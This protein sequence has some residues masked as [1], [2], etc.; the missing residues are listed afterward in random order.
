MKIRIYAQDAEPFSPGGGSPLTPT[1]CEI[2]ANLNSDWTL[3]LEHPLD[4]DGMYKLIQSG[5]VLRVPAFNGSQLYRII[6]A[7]RTDGGIT[8]T[9]EPIFMDAL[10]D[11]FFLDKRPTNLSGQA[12]LDYLMSGTKFSGESD[13]LNL[14]KAYYVRKNLIEALNG[15]DENAFTQRW[16]GEILFDN[17]KVII[18]QSAGRD[19]GVVVKYGR[20]LT[21]ITETVDRSSLITRIIPVGYNGIML[22]GS[23]PW[24]DSPLIDSYPIIYNSVIEYSDVKVKEDPD[25]PDEEGFDTLAEAQTEL[26]RLANLEY[27]QNNVDK[28]LVSMDVD[29]ILLQNTLEYAEFKDLEDISLGDTVK[30]EHSKLDISTSARCVSLTWDCITQRV[31]AV[32][33]GQFK[34]NYFNT[35][36]NTTN[37]VDQAIKPNGTVVAEQ[38]QGVLNAALTQ[39]KLQNTVAQ[40]Q[41]VRAIL[42]EDLDPDSPTY[43]A[44]SI[45]T[46]GFQIA[47]ERTADGL[48]WNWRTAF[49]AAG[50]YADVI[51]AGTLQGVEILADKGTI[52][53]W[54]INKDS[55]TSKSG[56]MTLEDD[57]DII[58]TDGTRTARLNNSQLNLFVGDTQTGSVSPAAWDDDY[59]NKQGIMFGTK[60]KY[61]AIAISQGGGWMARYVANNGLNPDG[62][63]EDNILLGSTRITGTCA[64]GGNSSINGS[65]QIY[66]NA[67]VVNSIYLGEGG[68]F[69]IVR[70][71][72]GTQDA[73]FTMNGGL[74][75]QGDL[76]CS[77]T[78]AR[79]VDTDHFG[80]VCL[81][82]FETPTP[83]FGDIG[84]GTVGPEGTVSIFLDPVFF[85]TIETGCEYLV[86][87]TRTSESSVDWVEK[88]I[89]HFIVHGEPGATFDWMMCAVQKGYASTRAQPVVIQ[90]IKEEEDAGNSNSN[91]FTS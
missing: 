19:K 43:G 53:G 67:R 80:K 2:T 89:D 76:G 30:C 61:A 78:K 22:S 62:M 73:L 18:N 74:Y 90:E 60:S 14:N 36:T 42:F 26:T 11:V 51:S 35:T 87:L 12:A 88:L 17:Y 47:D 15:E 77:G 46:Q 66:N 55:L 28:E 20:N 45:G 23:A 57:G 10:H 27:S 71:K 39:L 24:V 44:M 72:Y 7:D 8:A 16:G 75:A 68:G 5:A 1:R 40:K 32:T 58:S 50:G 70:G 69:R 64:I 91:G 33:L 82:A 86:Y 41:N 52:G 85:E 81:N 13:I 84:S 25:D 37:R 83:Y 31:T 34:P 63:N 65:L 3:T 4:S 6:T 48:D 79:V 21:G 38:V 54:T 59:E 49:T 56:N 9:A 29:L